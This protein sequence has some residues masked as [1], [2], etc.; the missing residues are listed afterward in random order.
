MSFSDGNRASGVKAN[1]TRR[2][3]SAPLLQVDATLDLAS[4]RN[5]RPRQAYYSPAHDF[6]SLLGLGVAQVLFRRYEHYIKNRL[7]LQAGT[8]VE[9]GYG[10]HPTEKIGDALTYH[11]SNA[12][13]LDL[14]LAYSRTAYDGIGQ[15]GLSAAFNV[16]WRF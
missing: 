15:N 1:L 11:S 12:L 5:S 9:H 10:S 3:Y 7:T 16:D 8:Y 6:E 4:S 14:G 13:E 2:L